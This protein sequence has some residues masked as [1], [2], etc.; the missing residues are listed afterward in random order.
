[1]KAKWK[2]NKHNHCKSHNKVLNDNAE[3][4][5]RKVLRERPAAWRFSQENQGFLGDPCCLPTHIPPNQIPDS[6]I[7][8]RHRDDET[9]QGTNALVEDS[10]VSSDEANDPLVVVEARLPYERAV[11]E[12]PHH[13]LARS[14]PSLPRSPPSLPRSRSRT[15]RTTTQAERGEGEAGAFRRRR[16]RVRWR[17]LA[18]LLRQ[19]RPVI[20]W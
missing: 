17:W 10:A 12:Y 2:R 16:Q 3:E 20:I 13:H 4:T 11:A 19:R 5:I 7:R 8:N 15:S 9:I 18:L 14:P 1:M 6:I